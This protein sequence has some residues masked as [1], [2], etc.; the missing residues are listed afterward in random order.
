M[1]F[2]IIFGL[3]LNINFIYRSEALELKYSAVLYNDVKNDNDSPELLK[4][5]QEM[6]KTKYPVSMFIV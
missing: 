5:F 2:Y 6:L 4:K 1:I 3:L